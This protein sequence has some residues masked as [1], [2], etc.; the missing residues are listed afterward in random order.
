MD[1]RLALFV[2]LDS[3]L[4]IFA[5]WT[6]VAPQ[7]V[8][9]LGTAWK[10]RN[11]DA[12]E[13]SERRYRMIRAGGAAQLSLYLPPLVGLA[14]PGDGLTKLYAGLVAAGICVVV[15][16]TV[17][18]IVSNVA[19]RR[20]RTRAIVEDVPVS[21]LSEAGYAVGRFEIGYTFFYV[22]LVGLI[23]LIGIG[24]VQSS[25]RE[26]EA[27]R[28]STMTPAEKER[29]DNIMSDLF[30]VEERTDF[31]VLAAVPEGALVGF[32]GKYTMDGTALTFT[33]YA[34]SCRSTGFVVIETAEQVTVGIVYDASGAVAA[35]Q[36]AEEF[37][38]L[39][40][41][42]MGA[43]ESFTISLAAELGE[44]AIV[45]A[46]DGRTVSEDFDSRYNF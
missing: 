9:S 6:I 24:S 1:S 22:I 21:E 7:S 41:R 32:P 17:L 34:R 31:E 46:P 13:P 5:I 8:W 4:V 2:V 25:Q 26:Y 12:M 3:V 15:I 37:C 14:W 18:V 10:Y 43:R 36:T 39:V 16:I 45:A 44:R 29:V 40:P 38:P 19:A 30:P 33:Q 23:I 27:R 42:Y 11:R 20:R 28:D 35:G